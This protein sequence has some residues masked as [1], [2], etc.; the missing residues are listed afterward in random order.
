VQ[1]LLIV[2]F[3]IHALAGVFWAG[4]T[5]VMARNGGA[6]AAQLFRPQMGAATLALLAGAG[7]WGSLHRGPPGPMEKTLAVGALCAIAAAAVQGMLR[8]SSPA[9]SQRLAAVLLAIT[10][11]C[12]VIARYVG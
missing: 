8:K 7:L 6:G 3:A 12:M 11:V 2:L 1:I 9:L 5:F 4:S 10:V